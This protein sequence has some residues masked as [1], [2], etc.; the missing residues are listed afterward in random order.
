MTDTEGKT[1]LGSRINH[2][3]ERFTYNHCVFDMLTTKHWSVAVRNQSVY[4]LS[5]PQACKLYVSGGNHA[6]V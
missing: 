5:N 1:M 2:A 6:P 4:L 3:P